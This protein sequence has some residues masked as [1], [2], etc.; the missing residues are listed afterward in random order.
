[1]SQNPIRPVFPP[2]RSL[3]TAVPFSLS[4]S[5]TLRPLCRLTVV[6]NEVDRVQNY[7]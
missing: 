6:S 2:S 5:L 1:M 4:F 3:A 7:K